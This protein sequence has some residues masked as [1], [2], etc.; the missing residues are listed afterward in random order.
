M[1]HCIRVCCSV[2]ESVPSS[3]P[4]L[5]LAGI[6][7][8][9]MAEKKPPH[10]DLH[11]M[12]VLFVIPKAEQPLLKGD[13]YSVHFKDFVSQCTIKDPL[14]RPSAADLLKHPFLKVRHSSLCDCI[15]LTTIA[16]NACSLTCPASIAGIQATQRT[17]RTSKASSQ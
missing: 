11:P 2:P 7:A 5:L 4:H 1:T 16:C 3:T 13:N 9:E 17:E 10:A 6:T 8:I 14:K 12:R 15:L